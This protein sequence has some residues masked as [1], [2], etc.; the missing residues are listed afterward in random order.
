MIKDATYIYATNVLNKDNDL[1]ETIYIR[2]EKD[3]SLH[4]QQRF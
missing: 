3:G 1:N 2:N 4:R